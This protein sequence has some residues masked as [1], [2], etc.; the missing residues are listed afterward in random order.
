MKS[1]I[2]KVVVDGALADSVVFI[3][4]FDDWLLEVS[5]EVKDLTV[6]LEPLRSNSRDRVINVLWS[7]RDT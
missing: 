7:L 5:T 6:I 1:A 4:V 2:F 3:W